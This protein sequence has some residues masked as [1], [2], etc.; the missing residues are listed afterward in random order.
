MVVLKKGASAVIPWL[1]KG[2]GKE[3][4]GVSHARVNLNNAAMGIAVCSRYL[5]TSTARLPN[6]VR[7]WRRECKA[8]QSSLCS[9]LKAN[10]DDSKKQHKY[11]ITAAATTPAAFDS[12]NALQRK[13]Q[14][15][16]LILFNV[17]PGAIVTR[18]K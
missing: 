7:R 1:E 9:A 2:P 18:N 14:F 5:S 3:I 13:T 8:K 11:T 16:S 4:R 10:A 6:I 12:S 15:C 17:S